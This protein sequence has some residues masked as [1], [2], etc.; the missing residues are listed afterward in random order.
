MFI[1]IYVDDIIITTSTSSAIDDLLQQLCIEFAIKDL[2]PINFF[3]VVEV[4]P[5]QSGL[6]LSQKRY[7]I[8][9]LKKTNM[10]EAKPKS[11]PMS[12]SHMLLAFEG[13]PVEDPSLF[14]SK[15]GSLQYL[16]LTR[17]DLAF[18]VNRVCQFMHRLTQP[19]L[20]AVKQILLYLKHSI[21]HGLLLERSYSSQLVA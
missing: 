3:L 8:D 20:Q 15:I 16:S 6:L 21:T 14:R 13:D 12:S 7:I 17:I 5:L 1:L 10:L 11:S 18:F 19:H 2:G 4:I 9:L